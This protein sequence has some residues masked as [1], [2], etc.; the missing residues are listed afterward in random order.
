[1][2]Y[3]WLLL[4]NGSFLCVF[5]IVISFL[6]LYSLYTFLFRF[7]YFCTSTLNKNEK[8]FRFILFQATFFF[9]VL[10]NYNSVLTM[11]LTCMFL[12]KKMLEYKATFERPLL[13][14]D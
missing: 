12:A 5:V 10:V 8:H 7:S 6:C 14:K 13:E 1:M 2:V 9:M 4:V 3:Y 11:L